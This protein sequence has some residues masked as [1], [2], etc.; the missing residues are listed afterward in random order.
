MPLHLARCVQIDAKTP[1]L[2]ALQQSKTIHLVTDCE[3]LE[4]SIEAQSGH[5]SFDH[6]IQFNEFMN[7]TSPNL[8]SK[9]LLNY[10]HTGPFFL[11]EPIF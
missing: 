7:V 6:I 1:T 8:Y 11:T 5:W 9:S 4:I 2:H 3:E 10:S